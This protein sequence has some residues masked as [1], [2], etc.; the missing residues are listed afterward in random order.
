[1]KRR[2][3]AREI[4]LQAL[5]SIDISHE[6]MDKVLQDIR[7]DREMDPPTWD[8]V[9]RLVAAVDSRRQELDDLIQKQCENWELDRV[10][11]LDKNILRMAIAEI[12]HFDDI[13]PKVSIDEAIELAKKFSTDKSGQFVNGILDPI[14]F[15]NQKNDISAGE[16]HGIQ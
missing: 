16:T 2:R 6:G 11:V 14:A 15:K 7:A 13:P 9:S 12:L 4:S 5:Y 3:L 8:Y 1:M 10:A